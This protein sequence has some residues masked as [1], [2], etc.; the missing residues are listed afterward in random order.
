MGWETD[1]GSISL[2]R[3]DADVVEAGRAGDYAGEAKV[4]FGRTL[5]IMHQAAGMH[6]RPE[7]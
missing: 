3:L 2:R 5:C 6:V 1:E 7:C 4:Q